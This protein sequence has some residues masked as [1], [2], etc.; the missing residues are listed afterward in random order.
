VLIILRRDPQ[1]HR[2]SL[3]A[4]PDEI[5]VQKFLQ[6]VQMKAPVKN[7]E[8]GKNR[9]N[10]KLYRSKNFGKLSKET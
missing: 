7:S 10:Q 9:Y 8:I 6:T 5:C 2:R 3:V 1:R 4:I